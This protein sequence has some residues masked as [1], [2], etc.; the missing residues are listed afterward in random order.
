MDGKQEGGSFL[1]QMQNKVKNLR[2]KLEK[3]Q[4]K[5][6]RPQSE[7]SEEEKT[8]LESKAMTE[9]LLGEYEKLVSSYQTAR[10]APEVPKPEIR[11]EVREEDNAAEVLRLWAVLHYVGLPGAQDLYLAQGLP[12]QDFE[13]VVG[14]RKELMG[15]P[16]DLVVDLHA[17]AVGVLTARI[18][19]KNDALDRVSKWCLEQKLPVPP[20]V[21]VLAVHSL[22]QQDIVKES[23]LPP[24]H[25]V[26]EPAALEPAA[27]KEE[28]SKEAPKTWADQD[29]EEEVAAAP[30]GESAPPAEDEFIV[31]GG[32]SKRKKPEPERRDGFGGRRRGNFRG[33]RRS[34]GRPGQ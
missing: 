4:E 11:V 30:T 2:R 6:K 14:L 32:K 8:Q 33:D 5:E 21:P 22:P 18:Q 1:K 34:R 3:I 26:P 29:D 9:L 31:V 7:L 12:R 25:P 23:V 28:E 20:P 17:A 19:V 15:K 16:G 24:V 27:P 13:E 10:E